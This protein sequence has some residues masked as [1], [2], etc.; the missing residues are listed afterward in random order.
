MMYQKSILFLIVL[1]YF[2]CNQPVGSEDIPVGSED[3]YG[4]TITSACNFNSAA[5][6]FDDS[7]I[8]EL[9]CNSECGTAE[10]DVCGVCAGGV[11]TIDD[12]LVCDED[13]TLGCDGNCST[14]SVVLDVCNVCGGDSS[15]CPKIMLSVS[16]SSISVGQST[17]LE[18][19]LANIQNLYALSFEIL[20]NHS[21]LE[22]D[23]E[24]GVVSYDQFTGDNFGPVVYSDDGVLSFVLGGNNIDGKIFSVT[25]RGLQADTTN[26]ALDKVNLIQVDGT[27]VPN[28][29][30]LVLENVEITVTS[31]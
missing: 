29:N 31:E 13:L 20:F 10:I 3:I 9:D 15:S 21:I 18:V 5:T 1:F 12:C 27:D 25:M 26:V 14:D 2:G 11:L 30:S 23:M 7:C 22:I 24:S 28:F 4:C 6:I 19:N 8:N 16:P 17:T